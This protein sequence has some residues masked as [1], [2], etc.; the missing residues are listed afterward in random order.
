MS[1]KKGTQLAY[2]RFT[3]RSLLTIAALAG[4]ACGARHFV[5]FL[6]EKNKTRVAQK[7]LEIWEG[8][9]GAVPVAKTKTAA[10]ISPQKLSNASPGGVN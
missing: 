4:L 7:R 8:E 2:Q 3:M 10:Q 9:G 5:N 1:C 6:S